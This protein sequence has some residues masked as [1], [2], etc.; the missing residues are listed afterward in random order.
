M[1]LAERL[2]VSSPTT[3][4][5]PRCLGESEIEYGITSRLSPLT[6]SMTPEELGVAAAIV[7]DEAAFFD[8]YLL[9]WCGTCCSCL[10]TKVSQAITASENCVTA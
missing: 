1:R 9:S 2:R 8:A 3:A 5:E 6:E 4:F 10:S 7:A